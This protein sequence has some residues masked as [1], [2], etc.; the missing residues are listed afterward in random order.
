MIFGVLLAGG[1]ST[2][3]S[4][5]I[6]LSLCTQETLHGFGAQGLLHRSL[7]TRQAI[8]LSLRYFYV[9]QGDFKNA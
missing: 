2:L 5:L 7:G 9:K 8:L 3:P 4:S 1:F 6:F